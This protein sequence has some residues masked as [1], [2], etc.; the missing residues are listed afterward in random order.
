VSALA[1]LDDLS[2]L[3]VGFAN[4]SVTVI[5]GDLIHDRGAKQRTVFESQEPITGLEVQHGP[6]TMLYI[7]TTARILTFVIAGKGQGQPARTLE[8]LGCGVGCMAFD[9]ITG[10]IMIAREDAIYTYGPNG[11][12]PS[13]AFDSPKTAINVFGDY[14]A[15]LCP[16]RTAKPDSFRRFGSSQV[17]DLFNTSTFTLLEPDLKFIAHSESLTSRVRSIFMEWG[18]LFLVTVDGKVCSFPVSNERFANLSRF[19]GIK[20]RRCSKNLRFSI[21]GIYISWQ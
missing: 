3:A 7:A 6:M 2:Q 4:G 19:T 15:L 8:D 18:A 1:V 13:F 11:R 21:S 17:D 12:G 16:P 9:K 5:R 20:R 14:V 10:D